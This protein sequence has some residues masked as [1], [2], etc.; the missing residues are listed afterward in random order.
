MT[1]AEEVFETM[2]FKPLVRLPPVESEASQ[3]ESGVVASV[4]FAGH[5]RGIV[6]IHSSL[7]AAR[8]IAGAMLGMPS[9]SVNGE[10]PDAIG[11]VANM[12]AGTF[13]NKLAAVEPASNIAVP[14]VTVGSDFTTKYSPTVRR[15]R[16]P[17]AMEGQSISVELILIGDE[18]APSRPH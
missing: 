7:E 17:F 11:E 8:D 5:R 12:V 16:C 3:R 9:E 6:S 4:A 13:R 10:M 2:V 14:T 1:A 15:A 18:P